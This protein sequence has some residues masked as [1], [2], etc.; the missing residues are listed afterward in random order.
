M[1]MLSNSIKTQIGTG[2][3]DYL[4]QTE[5]FALDQIIAAIQ[6][7]QKRSQDFWGKWIL[8]K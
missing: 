5:Y 7:L 6:N 8:P 3:T 2:P 1:N 4:T